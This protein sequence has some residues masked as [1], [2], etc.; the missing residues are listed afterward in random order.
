MINKIILTFLILLSASSTF[1]QIEVLSRKSYKIEKLTYSPDFNTPAQ[2]PPKTFES[3]FILPPR[4][5]LKFDNNNRLKEDY[6]FHFVRIGSLSSD[7]LTSLES[8]QEMKESDYRHRKTP[9]FEACPNCRSEC[10]V[11]PESCIVKGNFY[12]LNFRD[13]SA[14]ELR[15]NY[16]KVFR[17]TCNWND[18]DTSC[19]EKLKKLFDDFAIDLLKK[20][21]ERKDVSWPP[22]IC[23]NIVEKIFE[24]IPQPQESVLARYGL[25]RDD[26]NSFILLNPY[27]SL[28]VDNVAKVN[29]IDDDPNAWQMN[30]VGQSR[31][32]F[33]RDSMGKVLQIPFITSQRAPNNFLRVSGNVGLLASS[34]DL[35][36]SGQ[37]KDE[38]FFAIAYSPFKRNNS[39]GGTVLCPPE[40]EPDFVKCNFLIVSAATLNQLLDWKDCLG[41]PQLSKRVLDEIEVE[42]KMLESLALKLKTA[43]EN[44][45]LISPADK[46]RLDKNYDDL[47]NSIEK[48][49]NLVKELSLF[50]AKIVKTENPN[51]KDIK[52]SVF[53]PRNLISP[54]FDI[55]VNSNLKDAMVGSTIFNISP[56]IPKD[57]EVKRLFNG[58]YVEVKSVNRTL[59]L[60]PGD[61]IEF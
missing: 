14:V 45:D 31:I 33:R 47:K 54:I 28:L 17:E 40:E 36:L 53:G 48:N 46:K 55:W 21:S 22:F 44:K 16:E 56:P 41:S 32:P 58:K 13:K 61:K 6:R 26:S 39:L 49:K 12:D 15:I 19:N 37:T 34:G 29:W 11:K 42:K 60:L 52:I 4:S 25:V 3:E 51:C 20:I 1:G 35:Q 59:I 9:D 50:E 5:D 57:F 38:N 2:Q 43:A 8:L 24:V 7:Y 27:F 30:L 10:G 23:Q 18:T